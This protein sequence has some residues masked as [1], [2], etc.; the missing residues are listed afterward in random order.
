MKA[1]TALSFT[2]LQIWLNGLIKLLPNI[3]VVLVVLAVLV[4]GIML[5]VTIIAP[6]MTPADLLGSLGVDRSFRLQ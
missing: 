4:F 1:N 5:A 3:I 6:S 2:I